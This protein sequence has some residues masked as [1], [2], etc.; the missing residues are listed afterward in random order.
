MQGEPF[1][2]MGSHFWAAL[3]DGTAATLAANAIR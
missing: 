1:G 3:A 2:A